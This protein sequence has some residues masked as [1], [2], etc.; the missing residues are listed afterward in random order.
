MLNLSKFIALIASF[1]C[2]ANAYAGEAIIFDDPGLIGFRNGKLISGIY[3]MENQKFGCIF[4]FFENGLTSKAAANEEFSDT[5]I[6][7]FVPGDKSFLFA[8]RDTTFDIAGDLYRHEDEWSI[9]TSRGQAGCENATG[10]FMSDLGGNPGAS[11]YKVEKRIP[12]I[13]IRLV[14]G[15]TYFYEYSGGE[16]VKRKGYLTKWNG[17]VVLKTRGQFSYVRFV[18]ARLNAASLGRVTTGWIR[19][20]DLVNPFPSTT[21][22]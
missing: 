8:D 2:F 5:K 18:D 10:E 17:V 20:T 13:G 4:L 6:L 16:F 9:R 14:A 1:L 7:T 19:T 21:E 12:A 3:S 22:Q 11:I 15:K